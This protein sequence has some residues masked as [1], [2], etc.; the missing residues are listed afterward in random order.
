MGQWVGQS[1][2]WWVILIDVNIPR[3]LPQNVKQ[4]QFMISFGLRFQTRLRLLHFLK[5]LKQPLSEDKIKRRVKVAPKFLSFGSLTSFPLYY[6]DDIIIKW[7][8][9]RMLI[10][11]NYD[12]F[13]YFQRGCW[14][15]NFLPPRGHKLSEILEICTIVRNIRDML[16]RN[17][18]NF[19][20]IFL[21]F[22]FL[23]I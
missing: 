2:G 17:C 19:P 23:G 20:Q 9:L 22:L 8:S 4:L 14:S 21:K 10:S 12:D 6:W 18:P 16:K 15:N 3:W 7:L 13:W 5:P 1:A 11:E